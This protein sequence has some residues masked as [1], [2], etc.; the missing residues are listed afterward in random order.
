MNLRSL[1]GGVPEP[2]ELIGRDHLID[3]IWNQL[4]GNNILLVAPRRFGKTG[5][6]RHVLKCPRDG[7]LPVSIEAGEILEAETKQ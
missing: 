7:Y 1:P 6:M 4:A 2:E 3:V 5:V